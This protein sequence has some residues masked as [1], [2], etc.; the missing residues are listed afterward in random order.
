MPAGPVRE[1]GG[2]TMPPR[3]T[4]RGV[5]HEDADHLAVLGALWRVATAGG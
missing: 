1:T 2:H 4:I 5:P 3:G